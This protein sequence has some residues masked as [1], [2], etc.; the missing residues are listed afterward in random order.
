MFRKAAI[1]RRLM[2]S[3]VAPVRA[4]AVNIIICEGEKKNIPA[5]LAAKPRIFHHDTSQDRLAWISRN[6]KGGGSPTSDV[7]RARPEIIA[8]RNRRLK[9]WTPHQAAVHPL[10]SLAY[11]RSSLSKQ[12]K[13]L[14]P[15]SPAF[16]EH[17]LAVHLIAKGNYLSKKTTTTLFFISSFFYLT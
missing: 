10:T 12:F 2:R 7:L 8:L 16:K 6:F 3:S 17:Q 5:G 14:L 11:C 15:L 13:L 4:R 9:R 1:L